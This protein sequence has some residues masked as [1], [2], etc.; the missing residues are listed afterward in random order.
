MVINGI[1]LLLDSWRGIYIPQDF[2]KIYDPQEWGITEEDAD[3][4]ASGPDNELYWE[5]WDD[6]IHNAEYTDKNGYK[7]HL[8]PDGDLFAYCLDRMTPEEQ[9]EWF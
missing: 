6:V 5:T 3:I 8:Y 7:Y 1:E 4:L 9:Q 2:V